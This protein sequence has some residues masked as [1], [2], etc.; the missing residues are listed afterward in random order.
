MNHDKPD[1][2]L[3]FRHLGEIPDALKSRATEGSAMSEASERLR[4]L[5]E[6]D[7]RI[8][9]KLPEAEMA[10]AIRRK[11]DAAKRA[12]TPS[13]ATIGW[14]IAAISAFALVAFAMVSL[15]S[16][17]DQPTDPVAAESGV[18]RLIAPVTPVERSRDLPGTLV[19]GNRDQPSPPVERGRDQP[20]TPDERIA[21]APTPDDGVRTKGGVPR[22]RVHLV[23]VRQMSATSLLD[24]DTVATEAVLQV[25]MLAGPSKWTAVVSIDPS[26]NITRHLPEQGDSSILVEGAIQAPHSFQLDPAPGYE[27]FVL[28]Q[29][30]RPF[31]ISD[32]GPTVQGSGAGRH[33]AVV[34]SIR[35]VKLEKQP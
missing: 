15:P 20:N 7:E 32:A 5:R 8:L 19:E 10:S 4:R 3:E 6:D 22:L 2:L 30:D 31:A 35:L 26:G 11:L 13:H 34:Q 16:W 14:R 23:D 9:A 1:P 12:P 29:S 17:R 27:R 33:P 18:E 28:L 21:F 24:G 25:S